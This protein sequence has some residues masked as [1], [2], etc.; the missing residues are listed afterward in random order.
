MKNMPTIKHLTLISL[1]L[2]TASALWAA[3]VTL[4][5]AKDNSIFQEIHFA[6][7]RVFHRV[8]NKSNATNK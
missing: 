2:L 1:S 4:E 3:T 5:P 8:R 7:G 6:K